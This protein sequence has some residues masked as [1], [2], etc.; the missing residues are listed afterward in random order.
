[1]GAW[2]MSPWENDGAADWFGDLLEELPLAQRVEAALKLEA[3]EHHEEIRAAVAL[4]IMLGRTYIWP[5]GDLDRHLRLA[6]ARLEELRPLY[7]ELGGQDWTEALDGEI[8]VLRARLANDPG[9]PPAAQPASWKNF[10]GR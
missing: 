1:M 4:L 10:W 9:L 6:I 7:E 5:V 3:S 2:G 8:A